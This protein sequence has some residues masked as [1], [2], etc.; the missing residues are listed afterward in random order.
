MTDEDSPMGRVL[1]RREALSLLGVGGVTALAAGR[2]AAQPA[3]TRPACV[4]RPELTE[5]PYFVDEQL[6]R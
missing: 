6:D 5:G 1:T 4:V 2:S 3:G